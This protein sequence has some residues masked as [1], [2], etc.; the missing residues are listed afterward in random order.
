MIPTSLEVA[1]LAEAGK[2]PQ[3][4]VVLDL[5]QGKVVFAPDGV[6]AAANRLYKYNAEIQYNGVGTYGSESILFI[7]VVAI[8][9]LEEGELGTQTTVSALETRQTR[10]TVDLFNDTGEI[11]DMMATEAFVGKD[12]ELK[13]AYPG[14]AQSD[15][16]TK[17]RGEVSHATLDDEKVRLELRSA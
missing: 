2:Q 16:P 5:L 15:W 14:V 8:G 9:P 17:F 4:A 11:S 6:L 3:F 7:N 10:V 12:V 13:L 1:Q